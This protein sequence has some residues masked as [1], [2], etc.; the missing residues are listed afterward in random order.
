M[1]SLTMSRAPLRISFFGGGT[2]YPEY[3]KEHGGAVLATAIDKFSY[4]TASTFWSKL[5]DYRIRV[6]YRQV[7]LVKDTSEIEHVVY[8]ACLDFLNIDGDI[9]LHNVADLPSFSGLGS[10]ST[11]TVSLLQALHAFKGEIIKGIQ[12]AYEAIHIERGILK[13]NVGCQDQTTAAV[14]GFNVIEFKDEDDI[15]IHRVPISPDRVLELQSHLILVFTNI[16]RR[17]S[18]VVKSQ[19]ERVGKNKD[20]LKKMREMVDIGFNI[21]TSS[22]PLTAFGELLHKAWESKRSLADDVSNQKI[23]QM[24]ELAREHGAI[25]GKLLGAGGGGFL[26]LFAPPERHNKIKSVFA[27]EQIVDVA[28]NAPGAEIIL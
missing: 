1:S 9:E 28:I 12:L 13:E 5:F 10:S 18:D 27:N 17:A 16:T 15:K 21:L 26:L 6:S 8:R 7:E 2:D 22:Q 24:Y 14:G 11:F 19:L 25:G 3:F 23:N 20:T 4:V